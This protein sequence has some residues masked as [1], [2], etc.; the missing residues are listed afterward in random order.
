MFLLSLNSFC[1]LPILRNTTSYIR[2]RLPSTCL[3]RYVHH[4]GSSELLPVPP[5]LDTLNTA[6]DN[7]EA[8]SWIAAFK[9]KPIPKSL[10]NFTFSR[11]SGPGGQVCVFSTFQYILFSRFLQN[12][13]KVN[14]KSTLRCEVESHWIPSWAK[15]VIKK[16]VR[17]N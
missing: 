6:E 3:L 2:V 17:V 14:T 1:M 8:R 15:P 5:S 13:N 16:S 4:H 7:A 11:S 10:V 9:D 12:V